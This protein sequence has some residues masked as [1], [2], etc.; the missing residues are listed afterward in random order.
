MSNDAS[1]NSEAPTDVRALLDRIDEDWR[2]FLHL[3]DGIPDELLLAPG[4]VGDW[5]LKDLFGHIAF[6]DEQAIVELDRALTSQPERELDWQA[7]NDRDYAARKDRPLPEQRSDM[8]QAHATLLE[9]LEAVAG[10]EAARIDRAI[11]GSTYEHYE[12]HL[13]DLRIWRARN[14]L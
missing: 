9:R 7:M 12:E 8:H 14:G 4:A 10:L 13:P 1:K 11:K 5:S 2:E 6:W 3:L